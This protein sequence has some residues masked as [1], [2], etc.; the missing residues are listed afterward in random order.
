M[1]NRVKN[2]EQAPFYGMARE[3]ALDHPS[4]DQFI[5]AVAQYLTQYFS[6]FPV[7]QNP[8]DILE[9]RFT[10]SQEAFSRGM[11][12]CGTLTNIATE[13]LREAGFEVKKIHGSV[14]ESPDHA[15]LSVKNLKTGEW[16]QVD[17]TRPDIN[18]KTTPD[19]KLIA[20]CNDWE[21]IRDIIE[22]AHTKYTTS[23]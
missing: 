8:R 2:R 7:K 17:L 10:P 14:P 21:E 11:R 13:M 5:P 6:Q 9:S 16:E 4:L 23:S 18:Y 12:S 19:H 22:E 15:W 1:K 20:E 3:I